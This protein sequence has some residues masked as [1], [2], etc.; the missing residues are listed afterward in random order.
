M[1][2]DAAHPTD[3][4]FWYGSRVRFTDVKDGTSNT[5]LLSET[6][7]GTNTSTTT[8]QNPQPPRDYVSLNTS[9]FT[10]NAAGGY[11]KGGVLVTNRPPECDN[12]VRVWAGLRGS[13]WFWGGRD[14]NS[15]FSAYAPPNAPLPDCGAH[16]RGWFLARS[17]HANGVN[18]ALVD[19]SVRFVGNDI[20]LPTWRAL[21]TRDAGDIPGDY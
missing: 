7:L 14:W 11:L 18:V 3:G 12:G 20:A 5:L 15:V 4:M 17:V 16:G 2:Y 13:S 9:V 10:A 21:A 1:N 8:G 19:G 6:L